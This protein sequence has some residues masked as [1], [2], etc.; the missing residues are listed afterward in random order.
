[1]LR[2]CRPGA[3]G[4]KDRRGPFL[5]ASTALAGGGSRGPVASVA[6]RAASDAVWA[7]RVAAHAVTG[8][9]GTALSDTD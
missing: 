4:T 1:M 9:P 2:S 8:V 3:I 6:A 5:A 7:A